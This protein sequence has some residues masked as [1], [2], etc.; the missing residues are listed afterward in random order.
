MALSLYIQGLQDKYAADQKK[1]NPGL[2]ESDGSFNIAGV[3]NN[4]DGAQAAV[5]RAEWNDYLVRYA[6]IEKELLGKAMQ[7]TDYK[8]VGDRAGASF[9]ETAVRGFIEADKTAAAA[10]SVYTD[11]EKAALGRRRSL[12]FAAGVSGAETSA[13]VTTKQ[14]NDQA[15][16]TMIGY[17]RQSAVQ[18]G[19]ALSA[20]GNLSN[21]RN[22]AHESAMASWNVAKNQIE[23]QN[24]NTFTSIVGT[25]FGSMGGM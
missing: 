6:P 14:N 10:G 25:G 21:A 13:R 7:E 22:M 23:A 2:Y 8:G 24:F 5:S 20:A 17:G 12:G 9:S 4:P 1:K 3:I 19:G 18:A 11:E 15:L 16:K